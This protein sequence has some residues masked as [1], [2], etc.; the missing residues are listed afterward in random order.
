[1]DR[2]QRKPSEPAY[3][4]PPAAWRDTLASHAV[5]DG[6][7]LGT[8]RDGLPTLRVEG[9]QFHSRYNPTQEAERLV[10]SAGLESGTPVL[11]VGV[12][13]G[14]HVLELERRGHDVVVIEPDH[15][16]VKL[17]VDGP[18]S[19][20]MCPIGV[21]AL[22][23]VGADSTLDAFLERTPSVL[24]HPPTAQRHPDFAEHIQKAISTRALAGKNLSIAVVG[25]MYGGSLPIAEYLAHA[26]ARLGHHVRYVNHEDA[27]PLY[28]KVGTTVKGEKPAAQLTEFFTNFLSEWTYAQVAEFDPEICIVLAQA[29]VA[30]NFAER[31]RK[32]GTVTA[33]WYVENWRHLPYWKGIAPHYDYFFH[34]QPGEF[35]QKLDEV[36]CPHHAHVQT[37]C[38][39]TRHQPVTLSE[40]EQEEYGCDLSF[41]G[42]GYYNRIEMF[43]GLGDYDFKIWGVHWGDRYLQRL[44]QSGEKRFD[45][46]IFMKIVAGSK[47]NLNLHSSSTHSGVDPASD[48]INPRVFEIAAAGGFQLCDP[49]IGLE[50]LF[51][52]ET[53]LPVYRD[54]KELRERIDHFLAHPEERA[55]IAKAAQKRVL[56]EHTYEQRAKAMLQHIFDAHGAALMKRGIRAIH[57]VGEIVDQLDESDP[58]RAWLTTLPA[59]TPFTYEVMSRLTP[60]LGGERSPGEAIFTY[61][62]QVKENADALAKLMR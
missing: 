37:A 31:L 24:V 16:L 59:E 35:E 20:A 7:E 28:Q 33:F 23:D 43:K 47:I 19:P 4:Q 51:D 52:F 9:L 39:P 6:F 15:D 25:P 11:V 8:S 55:A 45:S 26:F 48:A 50:K 57:S 54:L 58:L 36:G 18:L 14:Y 41:A 44:L 53:E 61:M 2:S 1:M 27:W 62:C 29:P 60:P 3:L 32:N 40:D 5:G 46:G 56:T 49:C 34:I 10:A 30:P 12:G 21:G 17:A 38:D 22:P 42:A 13:L